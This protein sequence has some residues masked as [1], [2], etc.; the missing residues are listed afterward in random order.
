[1]NR[2]IQKQL[3]GLQDLNQLQNFA[4]QL[5]QLLLDDL[6]EEQPFSDNRA[7]AVMMA[8]GVLDETTDNAFRRFVENESN[9]RVVL[10]DLL[11]AGEL[12]LEMP[13]LLYGDAEAVQWHSFLLAVHA[14]KMGYPLHQL[15]PSSPPSTHSPAGMMVQRAGQFMRTQ[16]QR[17]ATDRDRL[18]RKLGYNAAAAGT[19]S[20]EQ[21]NSQE[22]QPPVPPYYRSP[23]P[24]RYPEYNPGV[25]VDENE[26]ADDDEPV[27]TPPAS[28]TPSAPNVQRGTPIKIT[29]EEV[30]PTP[31]PAQ[32]MPEIRITRDQV[33]PPPPPQIRTGRPVQVPQPAPAVS[34]NPLAQALRGMFKS[35]EMKT[36]KLRVLVQEYPDGPGIYGLQ[37]QVT[38]KGIKS[39]V[40][41]TTDRNGRFICE[42]PVR[43]TTGL[44]Y[45][46]DVTWP[47]AEGGDTERKSITLNADR[48]EFRLPF[49]RRLSE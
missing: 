26:A 47:R 4:N 16:L 24:V 34:T 36:T 1:M 23:V 18:A 48:T 10:Y 9:L 19:P 13:A 12:T 7:R 14:F 11:V 46:V 35:E 6:N 22:T 31:P 3:Q 37:V 29:R 45:D 2:S 21:L 8:M 38:C 42:L 41:G 32:R 40:A 39:Y 17:S 15:D 25:R 43:L 20:L 49:Y 28:Q 44:T 27:S 33:T 5:H 30:V